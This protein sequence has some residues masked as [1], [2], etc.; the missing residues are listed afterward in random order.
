MGGVLKLLS[1]KVGRG[2]AWVVIFIVSAVI[3]AVTTFVPL[4]FLPGQFQTDF[5]HGHIVLTTAALFVVAVLG[6]RLRSMARDSGVPPS[7]AYAVRFAWLF[8]TAGVLAFWPLAVLAWLNAV[9]ETAERAHDMTVIDETV[10]EMRPAATPIRHLRL[11]EVR[12]DWST[13]LQPDD[14]RPTPV[15]SCV[16][17]K[18]REGRL[19]LDWISGA[20]PIPCPRA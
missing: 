12:G 13:D 2:L 19:G 3:M 15:G 5:V 9:G 6:W 18:V 14:A 11:R 7:F 4:Q 10:T 1:V 20:E 16:R 8:A 17:V